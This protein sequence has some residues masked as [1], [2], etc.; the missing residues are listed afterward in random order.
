MGISFGEAEKWIGPFQFIVE[1][2]WNYEVWRVLLETE[3]NSSLG[4]CGGVEESPRGG[5]AVCTDLEPEE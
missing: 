5:E 3:I 2:S 1:K 4:E